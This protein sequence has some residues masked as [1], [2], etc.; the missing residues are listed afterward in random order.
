MLLLTEFRAC[1]EEAQRLSIDVCFGGFFWC[2]R[3][4]ESHEEGAAVEASVRD[5]ECYRLLAQH[6][7]QVSAAHPV[8]V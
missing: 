6:C 5:R 4:V 1:S 8:Q 2:S 7:A 3:P